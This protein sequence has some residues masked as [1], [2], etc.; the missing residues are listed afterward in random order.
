MA[1]ALQVDQVK[2]MLFQRKFLALR[3]RNEGFNWNGSDQFP[4]LARHRSEIRESSFNVE[5]RLAH[6]ERTGT[7]IA[8][9]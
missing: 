9:G 5:G 4:Q 7:P 8:R 3:A 2:D 1:F 6:G